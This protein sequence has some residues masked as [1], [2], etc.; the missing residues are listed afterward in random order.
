MIVKLLCCFFYNTK[1]TT[2]YYFRMFHF[3]AILLVLSAF[4]HAHL[5]EN[6]K[7]CPLLQVKYDYLTDLFSK[8]NFTLIHPNIE[9]LYSMLYYT[10]PHL[11][12][13]FIRQKIRKV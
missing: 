4:S 13:P 3:L 11:K 5:Y 1:K 10:F 9:S 6:K 8:N 2:I 12:R 7:L